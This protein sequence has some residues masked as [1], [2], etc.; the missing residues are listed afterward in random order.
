MNFNISYCTEKENGWVAGKLGI[1]YNEKVGR[2]AIRVIKKTQMYVF[3][4][5]MNV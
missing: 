3:A 2:W 1:V 5:Y 4:R